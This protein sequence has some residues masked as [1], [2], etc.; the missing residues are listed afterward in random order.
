MEH[1]INNELYEEI[2]IRE[3]LIL[4]I[5]KYNLLSYDS[6]KS[7]DLKGNVLKIGNK[8]YKLKRDITRKEWRKG[9]VTYLKD[10]YIIN[11]LPV[12]KSSVE[13]YIYEVTSAGGS[14]LGNRNDILRDLYRIIEQMK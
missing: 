7:E 8:L 10:T 13:D 12:E 11:K 6:F 14:I 2:R 1:I 9:D 4:K 5:K 3:G